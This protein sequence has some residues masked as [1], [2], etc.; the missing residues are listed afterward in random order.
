MADVTL[1]MRVNGGGLQTG[2]LTLALNDEIELTAATKSGWQGQIKWEIYDY[3]PD[4]VCPAEW[5]TD[6][7]G[8]YYVL[9]S[10]DPPS[11]VLTH[12]GKYLTRVSVN[13]VVDERTVVQI[14]STNG[15]YDVMRRE[16]AQ[17]EGNRRSWV[18]SFK[19]SL[20]A[21]DAQ[22][23]GSVGAAFSGLIQ[24]SFGQRVVFAGVGVP[25]V[26]GLDNSTPF[27]P[28]SQFEMLIPAGTASDLEYGQ[29]DPAGPNLD[30]EENW[31]PFDAGADY[32]I[33]VTAISTTKLVS[34]GKSLAAPDFTT[35]TIISATVDATDLDRLTVTY[36]RPCQ[37]PN[38]SIVGL[39]LGGTMAVPRTIT[40]I[41][42]G[43][44]TAVHVYA[45]SGD[46]SLAGPDAATFV[47][48]ASRELRSMNGPKP[49]AGSTAITFAN[50]DYNW[51]GVTGAT[52][53]LIASAGIGVAD[54]AVV[55]S[56]TDQIA[57]EA[58][59]EA[60]NRPIYRAT[61]VN[62]FPS[63]DF[64]GTNDKFLTSGADVVADW[65]GTP[66]DFE[67]IAVVQADTV[68][69][70]VAD[71]DCHGIWNGVGTTIGM[72]LYRA[73]GVT[74]T[75]L[76]WV[77]DG[78]AYR[79]ATAPIGASLPAHGVVCEMRLT[80]GNLIA[81]VDGVDGTPTASGAPLNYGGYLRIGS[82]RND[83]VF[84]DG[85]IARIVG[86]SGNGTKETAAINAFIAKYQ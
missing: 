33:A 86:K 50:V 76:A 65:M 67:I 64:D 63:V 45:L 69:D 1:Q 48:G 22:V 34:V 3:P 21:I 70:T 25:C 59:T 13:G 46:L 68:V 71:F 40:S 84:L 58:A 11:F 31:D 4:F 28:G 75:L 8:A 81:S 32:W 10:A 35:P 42:S 2:G 53:D 7:D 62:G 79:Y 26:I 57:G 9:G 27:V 29:D 74:Y 41:V 73:G 77:Y 6:S 39:S 49:A 80:G 16:G 15:L 61:G 43:N 85:K 83:T 72:G 20:R 55:P 78:V 82:N 24:L 14:L 36:S 5:S 37:C 23:L 52:F 12:W 56:W 60:T 51:A 44:G 30:P 17:F 66:G 47:I 54:G 19:K 18:G 38:G